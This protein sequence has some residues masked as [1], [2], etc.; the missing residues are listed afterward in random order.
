[1]R[2]LPTI[3]LLLAGCGG[4]SEQKLGIYNTAPNVSIVTPVDG[5]NFDEG[6]VIV[7]EAII[8][9]DFDSSET[10]QAYWS[11]D[12]D[13]EFE[14]GTPPDPSGTLLYSTANLSP[15]LH[16]ITLLVIDSQQE[17]TLESIAITINELPDEPEIE[18][19]HPTNGETGTENEPYSFVSEVFDAI[20]DLNLLQ[21]VVNSETDGDICTV[22]ADS[23]GIASCDGTL[24]VGQ[25][26]L[27]FTVT[28]STGYS[29]AATAYFD[30]IALV[31]IDNDGDGY[32]ENQGDCDDT[33]PTTSPSGT[34]V[35]NG[36]DDDCDGVIDNNTN[37]YDDDGDGYS[38][39]DGDCDDANADISPDA[40]EVCND[41][42]DNDCNGSQNAENAEGC[43]IYYRDADNDGFGDPNAPYCDCGP[44]GP[45]GTFN[46][47]NTL[48]CFDGNANANPQQSGFFATHRGDGS[49]DYNCDNT[50]EQLYPVSGECDDW[51]SN[52]GDC[53]LGTAGWHG[54][55][56]ACGGVGNFLVD[57]DS[58]SAGC[59]FLGVPFC[60][61]EAGP[62]YQSGTAQSCR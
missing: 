44:G 10:L 13:G 21:V 52:I 30:V 39:N 32:T 24:T 2:Y 61:V 34:E 3:P 33:D 59:E 20:D 28:N 18:I 38:E 9:D 11:S 14:G 17:S 31:E 54:G 53:T 22:N 7:F 60:C 49:Y 47:S 42:I 25:H 37:A 62:S 56:P 5:A 8:G 23:A 1:M 41:G 15:G 4:F 40:V 45:D 46:S 16:T 55:V 50:Q 12:V 27:T 36:I 48:D 51:G 6:T 35:E 43:S 26:L 57:N 19:V 29:S 58:C